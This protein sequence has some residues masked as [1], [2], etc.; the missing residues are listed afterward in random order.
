[1]KKQ[2]FPTVLFFF[3]FDALKVALLDKERTHPA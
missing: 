1:M 2:N 3:A